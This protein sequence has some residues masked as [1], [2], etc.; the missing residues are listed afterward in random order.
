MFSIYDL[1]EW[2]TGIIGLVVVDDIIRDSGIIDILPS[3]IHKLPDFSLCGP[4]YVLHEIWFLNFVCNNG[5]R[6][7]FTLNILNT[8][9]L[10]LCHVPQKIIMNIYVIGTHTNLPVLP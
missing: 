5:R 1:R 9:I 8:N 7:I 2:V 4:L 10:I 6:V 3:S